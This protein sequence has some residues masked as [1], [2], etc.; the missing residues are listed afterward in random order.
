MDSRV[1]DDAPPRGQ[2]LTDPPLDDGVDLQPLEAVFRR[3]EG[4]SF[5]AEALA[6]NVV[7]A[8]ADPAGTLGQQ[9][10]DGGLAAPT[11]SR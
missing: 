6:P 11:V 9:R 3:A 10:G 7:L 5:P 1:Y 4:T 8:E 2:R